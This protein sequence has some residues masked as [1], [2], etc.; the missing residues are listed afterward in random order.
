V[1]FLFIYLLLFL[2]GNFWVG[3]SDGGGDFAGRAM[4]VQWSLRGILFIYQ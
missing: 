4:G 3:D 1:G 2:G